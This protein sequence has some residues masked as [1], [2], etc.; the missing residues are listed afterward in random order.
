MREDGCRIQ[1]DS[2]PA[3]L[4]MIRHL[5]LNL[6]EQASFK[7]SLKQKRF[8][9]ALN[10][11]FRE[12]VVFGIKSQCACLGI[13]IPKRNIF[14]AVILLITV[15][16]FLTAHAGTDCARNSHDPCPLQSPETSAGNTR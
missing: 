11:N 4:A 12:E 16:G 15:I 14:R 9:A 3:N 6:F 7:L 5:S 8:K 13:R 1:M 10:D 2:A